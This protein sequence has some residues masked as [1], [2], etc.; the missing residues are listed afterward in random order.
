METKRKKEIEVTVIRSDR[1][2][3]SLEVTRDGKV[4]V[5]APKRMPMDRIRAFTEE[6]QAWI[7]RH[8]ADAQRKAEAAKQIPERSEAEVRALK[9]RARDAFMR[10]TAYYAEQMGVSYGRISIRDQKT[11]WG[12]C[13][14]QGNLN[15]NWRLILAPPEILDYVVVHELAHRRHMNHSAAF[16]GEV[17]RIMPDWQPRRDWLKRNGALLK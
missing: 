3:M 13:S 9:E 15:Y 17:S 7:A 5:R 6:K 16:W 4:I 2:T 11:R 12:S 8:V 10:R 1:K 14:S